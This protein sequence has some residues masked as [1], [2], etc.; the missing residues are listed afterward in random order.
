MKIMA[1]DLNAWKR[2][3]QPKWQQARIKIVLIRGT[4]TQAMK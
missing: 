3:N 4:V 2:S 1:K